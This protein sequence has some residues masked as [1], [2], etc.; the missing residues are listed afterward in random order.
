[1]KRVLNKK[2]IILIILIIII[3]ILL[4]HCGWIIKKNLKILSKKLAVIIDWIVSCRDET[5]STDLT[6][7]NYK[8]WMQH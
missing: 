7:I 1:M 6:N 4:R 5:V 2:I 3:K 8:Y